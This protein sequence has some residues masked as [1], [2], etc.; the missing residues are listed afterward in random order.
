MTTS[1][2]LRNVPRI[3]LTILVMT[4]LV[5]AITM[6][7]EADPMYQLNVTY[8]SGSIIS[9]PLSFGLSA[10]PTS[11]R[12]TFILGPGRVVYP[13]PEDPSPPVINFYEADALFGRL[14]FG[15]ATWTKNDTR[16]NLEEFSM[17]YDGSV[18]FLT[19]KYS[20]ITTQVVD[21]GIAL[22]F[23]LT[24]TGT[25]KASGETFEYQYT[26]STHTLTELPLIVVVDIK[27]GSCPNP[28]N[29]KSKGVLPVAILGTEGFDVTTID[30][31]SIKLE[32]VSAIRSNLEDV[33]APVDTQGDC[34]CT[35]EGPDDF[36]DMTLKFNTQD[37]VE[38]LGEDVSDGDTKTLTL[39]GLT[40]DGAE[41]AG[42]DCVLI[43]KKE[44][45]GSRGGRR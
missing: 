18:N 44:D 6:P 29:T 31:A 24:I 17:S 7:A 41:L 27:P 9:G 23:P 16:N 15:D 32:G 13:E 8:T 5:A 36:M 11:V 40:W 3:G 1:M 33:A 30:P 34:D 38:T 35:S 10:L 12:A 39:T 37:I 22:N 20:P 14:S 4:V 45:K 19:Y 2:S 26:E 42:S 25:D 28:L 43:L 21:G